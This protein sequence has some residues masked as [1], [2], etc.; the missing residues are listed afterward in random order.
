ME[1]STETFLMM[2]VEIV[3]AV[4]VIVCSMSLVKYSRVGYV[5][6]KRRTDVTEEL[7]EQMQYSDY[8][9]SLTTDAMINFIIT[10]GNQYKIIIERDGQ[11]DTCIR[12][13]Q[14]D[15]NNL[16]ANGK[17]TTASG[18]LGSVPYVS[19]ALIEMFKVDIVMD[20]TFKLH[21]I[22]SELVE[23]GTESLDKC[24]FVIFE[25]E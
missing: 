8:R 11:V 12:T 21:G 7:M 1:K 25:R 18:I 20:S 14:A 19:T 22:T 9:G 15:L 10:Y 2:C 23:L 6:Y 4:A 5:D 16:K 13:A 17:I 24:T 3:V